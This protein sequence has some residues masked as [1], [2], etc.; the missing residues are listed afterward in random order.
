[1]PDSEITIALI[2]PSLLG[3]YGDRGNAQ[4]LQRRLEWRGIAARVL[5]I[6]LDQD[7]PELCDIYLLGGGE[8]GPGRTAAALL[9]AQPSFPRAVNAGRP[10]LAVCAGMQLMG[11][12]VGELEGGYKGLGLLDVTTTITAPTRTIGELTIRP[13]GDWST[14]LITGFENHRGSTGIGPDAQ[15]LGTVVHGVGNGA[16]EPVEGACAGRI[17]ATYMHG[18]VLARNPALADRLLG[19]AVGAPLAPLE[20]ANVD[21]LRRERLL[22]ASR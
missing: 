6:G 22:K 12:H 14:E 16:G 18:P 13:T 4:V 21:A 3:T 8:D 20:M 9:A 7:I 5:E 1:M 10:V 17:I 15:P 2:Y 19:W 11:H